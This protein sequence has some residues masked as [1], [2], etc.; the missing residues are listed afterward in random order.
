MRFTLLLLICLQLYGVERNPCAESEKQF[1]PETNILRCI[2]TEQEYSQREL[3]EIGH[4]VFRAAA[5]ELKLQFTDFREHLRTSYTVT[6]PYALA[7][8]L[9]LDVLS[10]AFH[11]ISTGCQS[12]SGLDLFNKQAPHRHLILSAEYL[13]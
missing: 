2:K 4:Y 3:T 13:L 9:N 6:S 8:R 7:F 1:S 11:S 5:A 12:E 10:H